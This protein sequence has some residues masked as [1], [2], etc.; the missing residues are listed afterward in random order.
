MEWSKN[1]RQSLSSDRLSQ[2]QAPLQAQYIAH[3]YAAN[4]EPLLDTNG[5]QTS[6]SQHHT[7]DA[8]MPIV[9]SEDVSVPLENGSTDES[10]ME[11]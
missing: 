2:E 10:R 5:T 11:E 1:A 3:Q 6:P 7:E 9:N 4:Q 8:E